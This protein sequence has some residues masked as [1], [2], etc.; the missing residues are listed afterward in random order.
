MW[1]TVYAQGESD[2]MPTGEG[3][4]ERQKIS[5]LGREP[6]LQYTY[7]NSLDLANRGYSAQDL[8]ESSPVST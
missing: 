1:S 5:A 6:T 3:K 2:D 7:G 8:S 4:D